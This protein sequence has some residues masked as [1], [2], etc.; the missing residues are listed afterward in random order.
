MIRARDSFQMAGL[1]FLLIFGQNVSFANPSGNFIQNP[2]FSEYAGGFATSWIPSSPGAIQIREEG[3]NRFLRWPDDAQNEPVSIR[4]TIGDLQLSKGQKF[5][6]S[7][8]YRVDSPDSLVKIE[9]RNAK[10]QAIFTRSFRPTETKVWLEQKAEFALTSD[11]KGLELRVST[12]AKDRVDFDSIKLES[13]AAAQNELVLF[14]LWHPEITPEGGPDQVGWTGLQKAMGL[15][16]LGTND[17]APADTVCRSAYDDT[18]VSFLLE[19]DGNFPTD[20]IEIWL[21]PKGANGNFFQFI[22]SNDGTV[23][24]YLRAGGPARAVK[25]KVESNI[26]P[27]ENGWTATLRVP[28]V[29][30]QTKRPDDNARWGFNI[31]RHATGASPDSGLSSWAAVTAF[32]RVE[33]FGELAFYSRAEVEADIA[34]WENNEDDPLLRRLT[35]SGVEIQARVR[36]EPAAS[37]LWTYN[38]FAVDRASSE[39]WKCRGLTDSA[40]A[41]RRGLARSAEADYPEFFQAA[42][43][44][45]QAML[46]LAATQL[47]V[48]QT[49]RAA[50]YTS[51][52]EVALPKAIQ[53]RLAHLTAESARLDQRLD[54]AYAAYHAAFH[55]DW[56]PSGLQD[57]GTPALSQNIQNLSEQAELALVLLQGIVQTQ[58]PW[59]DQSTVWDESD[60][61]RHIHGAPKRL[62]FSA[63]KLYGD[64]PAARY[65]GPFRSWNIDWPFLIADRAPS[66]NFTLPQAETALS[67]LVS[68]DQKINFQTGFGL[69]SYQAPTSPWLEERIT[70]TPSILAQ[71]QDHLPIPKEQIGNLNAFMRRGVNISHPTTINYARDYLGYL[72][73]TLAEQRSLDFI[74]TGWED[75]T[76][77]RLR[78]DGKLFTRQHGYDPVSRKAF[79]EFLRNRYSS[80]SQLKKKWNVSEYNDFSDIEPPTDR[81][82]VE[83]PAATG[84]SYEWNRWQRISHFDWAHSLR[85][86]IKDV[87]PNT[88]VMTDSSHL[89]LDG[90]A[91]ESISHQASDII[92]FHSNPTNED[93]MFAYLESLTRHKGLPLACFENY[94]MMYSRL[95][96]ENELLAARSMRRYFHDLLARNVHILTFWLG[97]MSN[98]TPYVAAYGGGVF[99]LDDDQTILRWPSTEIS[100]FKQQ[101]TALEGPLVKSVPAQ[102]QIAVLI[103]DSSILQTQYLSGEQRYTPMEAFVTLQNRVLSPGNLPAEFLHEDQLN[104]SDDLLTP[105]NTI[106]IMDAAYMQPEV[107]SKLRAWTAQPANRLFVSGA[108]GFFN[109]YGQSLS[110]EESPLRTAFPKLQTHNSQPWRLIYPSAGGADNSV[111][112][113][114]PFGKGAISRLT[115]D[116][117]SF[118]ASP[119]AINALQTALEGRIPR[120]VLVSDSNIRV[121]LRHGTNGETYLLVSNRDVQTAREFGITVPG[122]FNKVFDLGLPGWFPV[123][124]TSREG[125]TTFSTRLAPGDW[126]LLSLTS[127]SSSDNE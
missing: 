37:S 58:F 55:A 12:N 16:K 86:A 8:R 49:E 34:Y 79:Q 33:R 78:L 13:A 39:A 93:A 21:S 114:V 113:T 50:Y 53:D 57:M 31:S 63:Y 76:E 67:R 100:L 85:Q 62:W 18:S 10:H 117:D 92:S 22:I 110:P 66:G 3:G 41:E 36:K 118:W 65:F 97:Y 112:E 127:N 47:A 83:N 28:F 124:T 91:W 95:E 70:T 48:S 99:R 61:A 5:Q 102:G 90:A 116:S 14:S 119:K 40:T 32:D 75:R 9:L 121:Q 73:K 94:G 54:Q 27:G 64:E 68:P 6:L 24:S 43:A 19:M 4:Q 108:L 15:L 104:N 111:L 88:P 84:L 52:L 42:D 25:L 71:T 2:E 89:L 81:F 80:I 23:Q 126:T 106:I 69:V 45:N 60:E 120:R 11:T 72:V 107:L 123:A 46:E 56:N 109:Q 125:N 29:G 30:L 101:A 1:V 74:V 77:L 103:P 122:S 105:F 87:A 7:C 59:T 20:H 98:A 96:G 17:P 38:P 44:L 51:Q 115:L 35:V 82:L 26:F